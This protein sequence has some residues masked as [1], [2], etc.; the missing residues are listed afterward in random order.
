M[1][2]SSENKIIY[3]LLEIF[4]KHAEVSLLRQFLFLEEAKSRYF[5]PFLHIDLQV[6]PAVLMRGGPTE[7][8]L[9]SGLVAPE[10]ALVVGLSAQLAAEPPASPGRRPG[11]LL[12]LQVLLLLLLLLLVAL[13]LLLLLLVLLPLLLSFLESGGLQARNKIR[14]SQSC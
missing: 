10:K 7:N 8:L 6:F 12:L 9:Q 3:R 11:I 2:F 4:P 14:D 13:L 1:R 5:L